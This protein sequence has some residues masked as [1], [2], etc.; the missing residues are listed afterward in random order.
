MT[1][2]GKTRG[3][4][5]GE[6]IKIRR[7]LAIYKVN[8]SPF[9]QVRV[10]TSDGRYV[11]RSTKETSRIQARVVAEELAASL[12]NLKP[13]VPSNFSFNAFADRFIAEAEIAADRGIRS[14]GYRKDAKYTINNEHWGLRQNFGKMDIRTISTSDFTSFVRKV[15]GARPDLSKSTIGI[16]TSTFR[17]VMK[18]ALDDG[19]I[20]AVPQT[21]KPR[22]EKTGTRPFFRFYPLVNKQEDQYRK[23]LATILRVAKEGAQVRGAP[24]TRE[25]YDL[26]VFLTNS[27]LRPTSSE[28]YAIKHADVGIGDYDENKDKSLK[29]LRLTIRKGKTGYRVGSTMPTSVSVYQRICARYPQHTPDDYL[30][31][32]QYTNRQHAIRVVQNQLNYVLDKAG[33]M[34]DPYTNQK[35]TMYSFRHT[36]IC[37]RLVLSKGDVNI[38][39][40]AK[41]AGTSVEIIETHYAKKL[42]IADDLVRNLQSFG[43]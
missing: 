20:P 4:L 28:L 10:R 11:V 15:L 29:T 36:A 14:E 1:E 16:I 31:F 27:F 7:G 9:Y 3:S 34:V 38:F 21:P 42:P 25:L 19:I 22:M 43:N 5:D 24:I 2:N 26:V 33:L 30:F 23:I 35:H 41:N 18:V 32:P 37:M 12:L 40:L 6:I 13:V 39:T 8:L 17:N